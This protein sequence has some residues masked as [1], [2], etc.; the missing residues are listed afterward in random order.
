MARRFQSGSISQIGSWYVVRF[1][2][3]VGDERK[4]TYVRVCPVNGP[5]KLSRAA[6]RRRVE[7]LMQ[8]AGVNSV[9]T[10]NATHGETFRERA[11]AFLRA[12]PATGW[13]ASDAVIFTT[14]P[15]CCRRICSTVSW[16][17]WKNPERFVSITTRNSS[18]VYSVK[19]EASQAI[20]LGGLA[21]LALTLACVGIYGVMAYLVMQQTREIGIRVALGAQPRDILGLILGRGTR[22][23]LMGVGVGVAAALLTTRLL[24]S[25]L[26][27]VSPMDQLM[28]AS[29]AALLIAA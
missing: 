16:E 26:F 5:N 3:D 21:A 28:I 25:L 11:D 2:Q 18:I 23:T 6:R 4:Q 8:Q 15:N 29:V 9:E 19:L 13:L 17:T 10:F 24:R 27:G 7:E 12:T 14:W 1:R 22:L 20:L